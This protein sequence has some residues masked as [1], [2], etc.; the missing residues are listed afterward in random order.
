MGRQ[1]QYF[2]VDDS[3][4]E[5]LGI[6]IGSASDQPIT[7]RPGIKFQ[8]HGNKRASTAIILL[9]LSLTFYPYGIMVRI[10][11]VDTRVDSK[12][13]SQFPCIAGS[14]KRDRARDR[15]LYLGLA[16]TSPGSRTS[17]LLPLAHRI[18]GTSLPDWRIRPFLQEPSY[19]LSR[20]LVVSS[21]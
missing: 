10:F 7:V 15:L 9:D 4:A 13:D 1:T 21:A 11:T 2:Q 18:S 5:A 19:P 14:K 20:T 3:C 6:R 8:R 12:N 16:S 17:P